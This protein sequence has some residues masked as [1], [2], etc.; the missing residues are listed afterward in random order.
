[1]VIL[2][3]QTHTHSHTHIDTHIVTSAELRIKHFLINR[4]S[5]SSPDTAAVGA[6]T[7]AQWLSLCS[8]IEKMR[9]DGNELEREIKLS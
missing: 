2:Y 9:R 4:R 8:D 6:G 7:V 5:G 3:I 1:M